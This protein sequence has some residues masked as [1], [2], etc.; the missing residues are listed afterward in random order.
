MYPLAE[1]V[2]KKR[3]W[4]SVVIA[5]TDICRYGVG[6]WRRTKNDIVENKIVLFFLS[7][8]MKMNK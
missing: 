7:S 1:P 8:S 4:V 5:V 3:F 6:G 2:N